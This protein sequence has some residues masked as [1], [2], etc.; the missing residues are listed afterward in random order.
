M[1][2]FSSDLEWIKFYSQSYLYGVIW[3]EFP[4]KNKKKD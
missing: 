1:H 3:G 2:G 4:G